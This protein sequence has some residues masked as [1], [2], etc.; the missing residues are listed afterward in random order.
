VARKRPRA[1]PIAIPAELLQM[2]DGDDH[3]NLL[4]CADWLEGHGFI[5]SATLL[6]IE[7]GL[8]CKPDDARDLIAVGAE[9]AKLA[10]ETDASWL[11]GLARHSP[12]GS[13]KGFDSDGDPWGFRYLSDGTLHYTAH[14]DTFK[15]GEWLQV[16]SLLVMST[17]KKFT[18]YVGRI[19]AD[20]IVGAARNKSDF[21]WTWDV[22]KRATR[23]KRTTPKRRSR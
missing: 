15:D 1:E 2:L 18:R 14:G 22:K 19:D 6:R 20:R 21:E 3:E 16:G 12:L 13:W 9:A 11:A 4:V 17:N 23:V 8:R 7:H 5:A 10:A